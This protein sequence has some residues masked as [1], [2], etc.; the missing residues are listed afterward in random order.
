MRFLPRSRGVRP[1][2]TLI[3][4]L[5]VIAIIA[6]LIGLLLPAVQKVREA[7]A[8]AKCQNNLKQMGVAIHAYHDVY[9]RVPAG[10]TSDV[11]PFGTAAVTDQ[12]WGSSWQAFI[13]PYIEQQSLYNQIKFV[14]GTGWQTSPTTSGPFISNVKIP[15]YRCPSTPLPDNCW[16]GFNGGQNVM[17]S[18]Y[19]GVSGAVNGL[20]NTVTGLPFVDNGRI[21]LP[22]GSAGCCSGGIAASNGVLFAGSATKVT[23]V[24]ITDGTSNTMMVSEQGDFLQVGNI[25][26]KVDWGSGKT[27]GWL[28]GYWTYRNPG[29]PNGGNK[30]SGQDMRT[31]NMAT[32]RYPINQKMFPSV[33]YPVGN[34]A[35][36]GICD[37]TPT[38]VPL[39]AAHTGGV[40]VGMAD[41][42]V[43]FLRDST[44]MV[45]QGQLAIRDDG[46]PM[47]G[48]Y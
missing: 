6:I 7:A 45:I 47:N 4:L 13:L 48:N 9:Q 29:Q 40:N 36:F 43:R 46:I 44:S 26:T 35:A 24:N 20:F 8:R 16:G 22:S 19:V 10:G 5:V 18:T 27:H 3:E 31:M 15:V 32:I 2:F 14:G 12:Q 37:N 21:G 11:P 39:N 34:C 28:I 1:G 38:N 17:A 42:S 41:G 33:P 25:L 30:V 23:L